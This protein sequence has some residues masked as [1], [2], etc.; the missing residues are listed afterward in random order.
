MPAREFLRTVLG[1]HQLH[2]NAVRARVRLE[3]LRNE[4]P[5]QF[6][7]GRVSLGVLLRASL[8]DLAVPVAFAFLAGALTP[9]LASAGYGELFERLDLAALRTPFM[10]L[11]L[12]VGQS[13]GG[14][15]ATTR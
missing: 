12:L 14:M 4:F 5:Q 3:V 7:V 6:A 9:I 10:T 11:I 15:P 8:V 2:Q 13:Q 1:W